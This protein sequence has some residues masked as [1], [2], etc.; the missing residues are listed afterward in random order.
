MPTT[1]Q[2][3]VEPMRTID[4]ILWTYGALYLAVAIMIFAIALDQGCLFNCEDASFGSENPLES[5]ITWAVLVFLF[6]PVPLIIERIV[7]AV[8]RFTSRL[9]F[10]QQ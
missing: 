5:P 2:K 10:R 1:E 8:A 3:D 6:W 4:L 7:K 9:L